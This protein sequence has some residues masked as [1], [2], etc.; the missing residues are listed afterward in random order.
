MEEARALITTARREV[1]NIE[2]FAMSA[3]RLLA[4]VNLIQK[5]MHSVMKKDEH[6]GT[7]PGCKKPSLFKPGA[8]KL[9]VT[10]RL[11][12][13]F[14]LGKTDLGNGHREYEVTCVLIHAPSGQRF[15]EGV[16]SCSTL[17]A[18]YRYR[19]GDSQFTGKPVPKAY[20]DDPARS[21]KHLGGVGFHAKKNPDNGKWEIAIQGERVE[22]EN[23][24]DYY[25]TVLKMAKKRAHV[26]AVLTATAASDIFTQDVEDLPKDNGED[27]TKDDP[28]KGDVVDIPTLATA[29][30][31]M[32]SCAD[33]DCL[34]RVWDSFK[35]FQKAKEF[36]E[37]KNN[38]KAE[39][40]KPPE[41]APK[42]TVI[43]PDGCPYAPDGE[44]KRTQCVNEDCFS[45]CTAWG[46][47]TTE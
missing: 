4:Q 44:A 24:A 30:A 26:D 17:E 19:S 1:V 33:L 5:V 13:E 32:K 7:I 25:N 43:P 28:P 39:L 6:Y 2:D 29:I 42:E 40:S 8:E 11:V 12:P 23:P 46:N 14:R 21:N 20:W 9:G 15:G 22:H 36:Q 16:G 35:Q 10:F 38:K 3:E 47:K 45:N 27:A 31:T 34:K 37:A 41:P 18:K